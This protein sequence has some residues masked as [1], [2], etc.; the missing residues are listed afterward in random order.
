MAKRAAS[1]SPTNEEEEDGFL[2]RD[3]AP[4]IQCNKNGCCPTDPDIQLQVINEDGVWT[5]V[6]PHCPLCETRFQLTRL[7]QASVSNNTA[8]PIAAQAPSPAEIA[9]YQAAPL[10]QRNTCK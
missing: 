8:H 9:D 1:N 4:Q 6:Q 2:N 10:Q 7:S 5:M 3:G